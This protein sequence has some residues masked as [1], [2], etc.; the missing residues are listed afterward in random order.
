MLSICDLSAQVDKYNCN[1]YIPP[2]NDICR[3]AIDFTGSIDAV[4]CCGGIE[5]IDLC[6]DMETGV[7]FSYT[8]SLDATVLDFENIDIEGPIG[9]EIYAGDCDNLILVGQSDCAGFD[10][11]S[12]TVPNC[13]GEIFIHVATKDDGCGAFTMVATDVTGCG[14]AENCD[15]ITLAHTLFP[16]SDQGPVSLSSCLDYSCNSTCESQSVWFQVETD[17]FTTAM[18]IE[19]KNAEFDVL[20]S[21][22]RIN[23]DCQAGTDI[24]VCQ[25]VA[26]GEIVSIDATQD[27]TFVIEVHSAG[28]N[29]SAFDICV[30]TI[31][32]N[33]DCAEASLTVI[34]PEY[35]TANP[36]GPYCPGETVTF[37]YDLEFFVSPVGEGN[38]CQWP[39]GIVPIL[40]GGW[41]LSVNNVQSETP[42]G[43]AYWGED[44]VDYNVSHPSIGL[45]LDGG[46]NKI[47]QYGGGGLSPGDLLP[48]GWWFVTN[49]TDVGCVNDGDPDNGWGMVTPCDDVAFL[50]HCF[51]LT[52]K[53]VTDIQE[54]E[55][56][57][58][59]DLSL[60]MFVFA[61]GETGCYS[62]SACTGDT[63]ATFV[64]EL[65]CSTLYDLEA[66]D[67]EICS[68]E[69]VDIPVSVMGGYD[70]PLFVEAVTTTGTT[71][72][73]DWVFQ[74]GTGVVPDQIINTT[75]A[76]Q[77][78][79]Y[80]VSLYNPESDCPA[81]TIFFDVLVHP[82]IEVAASGLTICE[83]EIDTL[84]ATQGLDSYEWYDL[85][86][87]LLSQTFELEVS[88][89]GI[90]ILQV[91]E[92]NCTKQIEAEVFVS[93]PVT[94][95]F[96]QASIEACNEAGGN[97]PTSIDLTSYVQA[98]ITGVWLDADMFPLG[99]ASDVDFTDDPAGAVVYFFLPLN[100]PAPC[101]A[102]EIPFTVNVQNCG[103][104]DVTI[105]PIPDQCINGDTLNLDDYLITSDPGVW[106][107]FG[108]PDVTSISLMGSEV[109]MRDLIV[110]GTYIFGYKV[111]AVGYGP[112]CIFEYRVEIKISRTPEAEILPTAV[113]CNGDTGTDPE[114]LDLDDMFVSG[115]DGEWTSDD[116]VING[117]NTV[118]FTDA[119]AGDYIFT[120]TTTEAEEPCSDIAIDLVVTVRD[121]S[122]PALVLGTPDNLCQGDNSFA[123]S[124]LIVS[125]AAGDWNIEPNNATNP[126]AI[127]G[128]NVEIN[129]VTDVGSYTLRYVLTDTNIPPACQ[130]EDMVSFEVIAPPSA[131]ILTTANACNTDTGDDPELI[132]LDDM[133]VSG[134]DGEW[135]TSST[136]IIDRTNNVVSFMDADPMDYTFTY[137]TNDATAPC[138]NVSYDLIVTVADC[139]CPAVEIAQPQ[140]YCSEQNTISLNDLIIDAG[141]GTWE[142]ESMTTT[143]PTLIGDQM[144]IDENTSAGTYTLTY[145]LSD[146]TINAACN[147]V[148]SVQFEIFNGPTAEIMPAV[149]ICNS[150]NGTD[151]FR[152]DL[153]T[154][155]LSGAGGVWSFDN[156]VLSADADNIIDFDGVA[157]GDY[158]LT[159]MTNEAVFP[160]SDPSYEVMVSVVDCSCP[161]I[162]LIDGPN[163]CQSTD[164]FNLD[165]LIVPGVGVGDWTFASGPETVMLNG[166]EFS[167]ADLDAGFYSFDFTL[168]DI[169]SGCPTTAQTFVQV[170]ARPELAL[171]PETEVCNED[172]PTAPRCIDLNIFAD[173]ADGVWAAPAGYTGDFSNVANVCFDGIPSGTDLEF[174]YTTT[175]AQMPCDNI[176][177]SMIV[178]VL[179][180]SCPN[181]S[182]DNPEPLCNEGDVLD[183]G[184]LETAQT[185]DGAWMFL[186]GPENLTINPDNTVFIDGAT[187]GLYSFEFVP[188]VMPGPN[189]D[190]TNS[191]EVQVFSP[192]SSG[193]GNLIDFCAGESNTL[194]LFTLLDNADPGGTWSEVSDN[195]S[196]GGFDENTGVFVIDN[197]VAGLYEFVYAHLSSATCPASEAT[198]LVSLRA[199]PVADAGDD[200]ELTCA[201]NTYTL[202]GSNMASGPRIEYVWTEASGQVIAN[203]TTQNPIVTQPGTYTVQV[204]DNIFGCE[205]T[206]EVVVSEDRSIPTFDTE[207]LPVSCDGTS[208]GGIVVSNSQGGNGDYEYS[209]DGGATWVD[210]TVFSDLEPGTYSVIIR[211]G[212]G[213]ESSV[214]GLVVPEPIFIG[215][216]IGEDR[217]V[218]F[219]SH[220]V[221]INLTTV[222]SAEDIDIVVWEED[223]EVLCEGTHNDCFEIEVDPD[224]VSTYC[225]S[226]TDNNGCQESACIV[227][228]EVIDPNLYIANVFS[229]TVEGFNNKFFVQSDEFITTIKELVI[230]NR[231]GEKVFVAQPDHAPNDPAFGWDGRYKGQLVPTGVYA[232]LVIAE[233]V[234]GGT[235]KTAGDVMLVR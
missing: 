216:D 138:D 121:C 219:G 161:F 18:Q 113:A 30:S 78:I 120:Y 223:G 215:L 125:A 173:S 214:E 114:V 233:D 47:L 137:T 180:C 7:W 86:N 129:D 108:G 159:Y 66:V 210:Q 44:E 27:F 130:T 155:V 92:G 111:E 69:F 127:A 82:E 102:E 226:V 141:A 68:G 28:G 55:R 99:N 136:L 12:M 46:N 14:A 106:Q 11:R 89:A 84:R 63:P 43:W 97:F 150:D 167:T 32:D 187:I 26:A 62:F 88:D 227:L 158:V 212:N 126:P 79:T 19:I 101:Q 21:V 15:D 178:H 50:S 31:Q 198:I 37:C 81:P 204:I 221:E 35:P 147:K 107:I 191:I 225:V 67:G 34:R 176:S 100:V 146:P 13:S 142:L 117:D 105:D 218:Q 213:C 87:N 112:N 179:D 177:A 119:D 76:D 96:T 222:A 83:G 170:I 6:G 171:A 151:P 157:L 80:G 17:N 235:V 8:Q 207:V 200:F 4:T 65:D 41:D 29:A 139:S 131:T 229:P 163:L 197:E 124:D 160:C 154:L 36:L 9:I 211:D 206:D 231:W 135:S 56:D 208:L 70:V 203:S 52:T 85:D 184:A 140:D 190:Q 33:V 232:Y 3:D 20:L 209:I 58:D 103:C 205:G 51:S 22:T 73:Q 153:D 182:L 234:T 53:S 199:A 64:G 60:S 228:T 2:G 118:V 90:Y 181:L 188:T 95:P 40:G 143:P 144:T 132:D 148:S 195:T 189:C 39:Q 116:F 16:Q 166:S 49:G 164:I 10:Q 175:T 183:L 48:A 174:T 185:V 162:N 122:C 168:Q 5:A 25:P 61:D 202:G 109:V 94:Q 169:V 194:D 152:I 74:G 72:A 38:N 23:N 115:A 93:E 1:T 193:T 77:V 110:P 149:A 45:A 91:T 75:G 230:M 128:G 224:G 192:L 220:S 59:R 42:P 57:Y 24:L 156:A 54:C 217:E 145:T 98:G 172:N 165:Q 134:S 186:S 201:E 133:F 123:L 71:G 196:G 104:P